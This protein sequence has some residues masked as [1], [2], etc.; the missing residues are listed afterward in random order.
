M[1]GW[2]LYTCCTAQGVR[3]LLNVWEA[4]TSC[5]SGTLEV[6]F[7]INKVGPEG[8]VR[9]WLPHDGRIE[10]EPVRAQD[11]LVRLPTWVDRRSLT[12]HVDGSETV[13]NFSGSHHVRV[14][15]VPAGGV[16]RIT[17]SVASATRVERVLGVDYTTTWAGDTVIEITPGGKHYP[18]YTGRELLPG[19]VPMT[20]RTAGPGMP[21]HTQ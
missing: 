11:V 15:D 1:H 18:L 13:L 20:T 19:A 21:V 12:V 6:D 10:V 2:D 9:S 4:A 7:L 14:A 8:V 16:V 5:G 3:G 17:F